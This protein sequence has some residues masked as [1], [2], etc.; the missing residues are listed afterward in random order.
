[1]PIN[2]YTE[3]SLILLNNVSSVQNGAAF[4]W[5]GGRGVFSS[6][7]TGAAKLQWSPDNGTTWLDVD[8]SGDT[9]VTLTAAGAGL[10]ELPP[11]LIRAVSS[12]TV[13]NLTAEATP[14][15]G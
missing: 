14:V 13:T 11:C 6:I 5:R 12:G 2:N 4:D 3:G 8:R 15:V 7:G 1:M 9:F 10:F